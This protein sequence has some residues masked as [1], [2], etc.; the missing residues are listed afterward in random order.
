MTDDQQPQ[1]QA[2]NYLD[3]LNELNAKALRILNRGVR[4]RNISANDARKVARRLGI[5]QP[6]SLRKRRVY[7][8]RIQLRYVEITTASDEEAIEKVKKGI[9]NGHAV[10]SRD[11]VYDNPDNVLIFDNSVRHGSS[12]STSR[13]NRP[14]RFV[15]ITNSGDLEP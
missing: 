5:G 9:E 12:F 15:D 4:E 7:F 14:D 6:D 1:G 2:K 13:P 8:E 11:G 10:V 3:D